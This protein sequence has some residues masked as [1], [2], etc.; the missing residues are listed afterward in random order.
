MT[1]K[2]SHD[3]KH[4][5]KSNDI[6][7]T[8]LPLS[9]F[10]IDKISFNPN[11]KWLDPFFGQGSYFNQFPTDH[12]DWTEIEKEKDFFDYNEPCDIICSN[13]PYSMIDKVLSKSVSLNPRI[14][15]Y[16]INS[17]NLTAKR[18]EFMNDN[19]YGLT[20]LHLTKV[21]KWY[22]MSYIVQFEKD[23]PNVISFDRTIW[24]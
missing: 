11:D 13:P 24:R 2:I 7:Y 15:S 12:K 6:F 10:Q 19:G 4:R 9:K 3:I 5:T 14:I 17:N 8:P 18:I 22:G 23:K 20:Y 16:L 21:F 1:S